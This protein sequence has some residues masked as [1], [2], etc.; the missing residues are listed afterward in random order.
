MDEKISSKLNKT[1][2]NIKQNIQS[3]NESIF[4]G[5]N[6]KPILDGNKIIIHVFKKVK[7]KKCHKLI[8]SLYGSNKNFDFAG[9][10]FQ[11]SI[12]LSKCFRFF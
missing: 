3:K 1:K 4:I 10:K 11:N 12:I 8:K 2:Y 7:R 5:E 9:F 6:A